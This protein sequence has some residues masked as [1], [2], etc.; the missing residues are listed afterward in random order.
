MRKAST[1][2]IAL[3]ALSCA[4]LSIGGAALSQEPPANAPATDASVTL[5]EEDQNAAPFPAAPNAALVKKVCSS[6][7]P[8]TAVLDM[9]FTHDDAELYY[10]NMVS[11]DLSTD[12]ARKVIEYLST[13]LGL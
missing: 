4:A 7:H 2:L 3:A 5:S 13:A 9:R 10:A 1:T 12:Q 6:C 8:P 11:S